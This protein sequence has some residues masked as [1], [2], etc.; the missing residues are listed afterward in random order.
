MQVLLPRDSILCRAARDF[1]RRPDPEP[2][3]AADVS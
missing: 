3:D 1:Q 2:T